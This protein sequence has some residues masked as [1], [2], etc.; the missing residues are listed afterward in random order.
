M[1]GISF[2]RKFGAILLVLVLVIGSICLRDAEQASA[3]QKPARPKVRLSAL[4]SG[5]GI[6]VKIG[7]TN[8]ATGYKVMM[9]GS[10]DNKYQKVKT[11]NTDTSVDTFLSIDDL[12]YGT[13]RVKVRAYTNV[14]GTVTWGRY[15]KAKKIVLKKPVV[16]A[17]SFKVGDVVI[18]GSFEAD[19]NTENGKEP[20]EWVVLSN[21]GSELF[22]LTRHII[23]EADMYSTIG[24]SEDGDDEDKEITW[25]NRALRDYLNGDFI[26][27]TFTDKEAAVIADTELTDVNTT[28]KVFLLSED[29]INNNEGYFYHNVSFYRRCG[30]TKFAYSDHDFDGDHNYT[31]VW[32]CSDYLDDKSHQARDGEFACYWWLRTPGWDEETFR[33]V[34]ETGS[35]IT[36]EYDES[37]I[38]T[39][40]EDDDGEV[41]YAEGFGLRPALK[42]NLTEDALELLTLTGDNDGVDVKTTSSVNDTIVDIAEA[43]QGDII[44]FGTYEQ[45]NDTENGPEPISWIVLQK[46]GSELLVMSKYGL[47]VQPFNTSGGR[48][49]WDDCSL[50]E[51]L[52]NDFYNTAFTDTEKKKIKKKTVKNGA[53]PFYSSSSA[54]KDTKD[55]VFLLSIDEA[56][57]ASYGFATD[58][59]EYDDLRKCAPTEYAISKGGKLTEY[60]TPDGPFTGLWW[61]RT[62][63]SVDYYTA[64]VI[65]S[66]YIR[67]DGW[68]TDS[69]DFFI[70]PVIAISLK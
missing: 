31:S 53:N 30:A 36:V 67:R 66:G 70:R 47:D 1:K 54:G 15:C 37:E 9:K 16:D 52:N 46:T 69:G 22:L 38:E 64:Y 33:M 60:T 13:Y 14:K 23:S 18:F 5:R 59:T 2:A 28:D 65:G 43:K 49:R 12:A 34:S 48:V 4:E 6:T 11:F 45:D 7:K 50:R 32:T 35:I 41:F 27:E 29:E 68:D 42:V 55:K 19:D 26:K 40:H 44:T 10:S 8:G 21:D 57:N 20:L 25:E 3:A 24:D 63:G 62:V 61:L 56:V 51:W 39:N 17:S 58:R